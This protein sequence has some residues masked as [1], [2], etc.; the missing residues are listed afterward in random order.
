MSSPTRRSYEA[1]RRILIYLL[2]TSDLGITY[3]GGRP[4]SLRLDTIWRPFDP[5]HDAACSAMHTVSDAN[6]E[7]GRSCTGFVIMLNGAAVAWVAKKQP[8]N[9][10]ELSRCRDV[11]GGSGDRGDDMG[12]GA[13]GGARLPADWANAAV[14]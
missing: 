11:R 2:R 3:G 6:W 12:K 4:S 14:G 1:S 13:H 7:T 8:A 10:V 9:G 5:M